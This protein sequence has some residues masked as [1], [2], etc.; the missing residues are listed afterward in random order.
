MK[1]GLAFDSNLLGGPLT[2]RLM[3]L[4]MELSQASVVILPT[5]AK[6]LT[7]KREN[8]TVAERQLDDLYEGVWHESWRKKDTPY[9]TIELTEEQRE[10]AS[11]MLAVFTIRCFPSVFSR[12]EIRR[13][14]D[15]NIV[16]EA[17][18]TG[19]DMVVTNNMK[20]IDHREVNALI[21]STTGTNENIVATADNALLDAHD[22]GEGSRQLLRMFLA[23]IWPDQ[24]RRTL[25]MTDCHNLLERH[26]HSLA[27]RAVMPDSAVKLTNA[28]NVDQ[29]LD[30]VISDAQ[31]LAQDSSSLRHDN[32]Q[33]ASVRIGRARIDT[34]KSKTDDGVVGG[35]ASPASR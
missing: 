7:Y 17:V 31:L 6:E 8:P 24:G 4:W 15:A 23:T 14:P 19:T 29:H 5:V 21:R 32:E 9:E 27:T 3:L 33:A 30:L 22:A 2:R 20:S 35:S 34:A 12:S 11:E 25:S 1:Q 26:T 10:V 16:A 18:A 28:F 13:L